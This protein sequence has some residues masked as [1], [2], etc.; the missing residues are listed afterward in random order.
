M[1]TTYYCGIDLGTSRTSIATSTGIRYTTDS[2]VGYAKD[3]I[4]SKRFGAN[5]LL[6]KDAIE[7]RLSLN[8][9]W[10]LSNGVIN[11]DDSL[12]MDT[13]KL[14][15]KNLLAYAI[16]DKKDDDNLMVAIGVPA[17]AGVENKADI[18]KIGN[19]LVSKTLIVSEPF[20]V[21]YGLDRFDE[22][23]M[24]DCGAGTVDL[25]RIYGSFPEEKDQITLTTAGNFLDETLKEAILKNHPEVQLTNN[26]VKKLK[27][28]YGFVT[29]SEQ[30]K[31]TFREGG[32][33]KTYDI[34]SQMYEACLKFTAP[35][36]EA[37]EKLISDFDPEFQEKLRNNIIVAGGGSRLKGI[38]RE[39]EKGLIPYGGGNVITVQDAEFAG[40]E[41]ALKMALEMPE[42]YWGKL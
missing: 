20:A 22:V 32:K 26:I 36:C 6:G 1:G 15:L 12:A 16:P 31:H 25:V 29:V 38:D 9:V 39:I 37:V 2:V 35:I 11:K 30:I 21:A 17:Q 34:T 42:E 33:P 14:I 41:G 4:S 5:Y 10:P 23:L 27:E 19:D 18:L 40:A 3:L 24:I 7:N 13:V 28:K 8:M